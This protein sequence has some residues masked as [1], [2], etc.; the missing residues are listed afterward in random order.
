MKQ[1]NYTIW[2]LCCQRLPSHQRLKQMHWQLFSAKKPIKAFNPR[3]ESVVAVNQKKKK[4][5]VK[6][7][8]KSSSVTVMM[9][10][11]T[12]QSSQKEVIKKSY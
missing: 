2:S 9:M 7:I 11:S 1:E 8:K 3:A 6:P 10:Q 12:R 4:A 5:A